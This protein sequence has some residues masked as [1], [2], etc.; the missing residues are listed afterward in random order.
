MKRW[1]GVSSMHLTECGLPGIGQV[2]YG[3]HLC[4][5][6]P[7]RQVLAEGLV[8]YFKAGLRNNER[9]IWVAGDPMPAVDAR[10][11]IARNHPEM[12]AAL[13]TG[14]LRIVDGR[15]WYGEAGSYVAADLIKLWADAEKEALHA[16]HN[17]LRV[18]GNPSFL[19]ASD[20]DAFMGYERALTPAMAG[21]R[22][23]ALCSYSLDLCRPTDMLDVVRSHHA[24]LDRAEGDW[25]VRQDLRGPLDR[26]GSPS[27]SSGAGRA[28]HS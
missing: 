8:A 9:C 6:Y 16:G 4:H 2:A 26:A 11:E 3:V 22:I 18:T 27:R 19:Q 25:L 1:N 14:L 5:F 13:D 12:M 15:D 10:D 17:G 24:T 21:T 28:K 7:N 23:L 20:W